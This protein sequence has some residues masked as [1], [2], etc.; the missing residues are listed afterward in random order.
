MMTNSFHNDVVMLVPLLIDNCTLPSIHPSFYNNVQVIIK[1]MQYITQ[2]YTEYWH[3]HCS[4]MITSYPE[5]V[6]HTLLGL[7]AELLCLEKFLKKIFITSYYI[8]R[9]TDY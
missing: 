6:H 1:V 7:Y 9:Y 3:L 2:Y 4:M 8:Q 5:T